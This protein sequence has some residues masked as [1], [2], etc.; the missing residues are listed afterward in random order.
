M[1]RIA[2][3]VWLVLGIT[4]A[5]IA[6]MVVVAVPELFNQGME[7]IPIAAGVGAL[8]AV[9][10]AYLIAKRIYALTAPR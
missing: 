4:L 10:F 1:L 3:L 8:I 7:L 9:P 5:G 2:I 6:I